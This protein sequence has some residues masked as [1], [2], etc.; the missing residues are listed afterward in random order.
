MFMETTKFV[1]LLTE[2]GK[3]FDEGFSSDDHYRDFTKEESLNLR[4]KMGIFTHG[5][6]SLSCVG[7]LQ[8]DS[9]EFIIN[10]L[11][12]TGRAV[13]R[14]LTDPCGVKNSEECPPG[15][16]SSSRDNDNMMR[17]VMR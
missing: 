6:A 9:D 3:E 16:A 15:G 2:M 5:L 1:Q 14:D 11:Y 10:L 4:E 8:D 17:K 13:I 12:E 7:L